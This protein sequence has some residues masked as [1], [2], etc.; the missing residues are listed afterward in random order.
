[1]ILLLTAHHRVFQQKES[2][3]GVPEDDGRRAPDLMGASISGLRQL[4]ALAA[5]PFVDRLIA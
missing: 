1:V 4:H 3:E 5:A 2:Q